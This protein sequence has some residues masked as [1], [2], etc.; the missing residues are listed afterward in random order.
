MEIIVIRTSMRK[1]DL[2]TMAQQQFGDMVK[3]VVDVEQRIMAIG[4]E[5]HS[6]ESHTF[7]AGLTAKKPVGHQSLS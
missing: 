5:L 3:A 1:A 2:N 4:G 7:R 6:D